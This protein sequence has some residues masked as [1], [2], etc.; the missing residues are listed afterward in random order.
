MIGGQAV[1]IGKGP[2][3]RLDLI[4]RDRFRDCVRQSTRLLARLR[5]L[6][7][8]SATNLFNW[9]VRILCQWSDD[10]TDLF[11]RTGLTSNFSRCLYL[12]IEPFLQRVRQSKSDASSAFIR[13]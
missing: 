6:L 1:G 4:Q 3:A 8:A 12:S 9:R 11:T 7:G 5:L 10:L 13:V 2:A